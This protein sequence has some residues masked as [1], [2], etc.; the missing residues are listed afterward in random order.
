MF[1]EF[2]EW[3]TTDSWLVVATVVAGVCIVCYCI[4]A[5]M[6]VRGDEGTLAWIVAGGIWSVFLIALFFP[7][8]TEIPLPF[9]FK[10]MSNWLLGLGVCFFVAE[11]FIGAYVAS[12]RKLPG[13]YHPS[14]RLKGGVRRASWVAIIVIGLAVASV[15]VVYIVFRSLPD[16]AGRLNDTFGVTFTT[17]L[18][19][20]AF[21]CCLGMAGLLWLLGAIFMNPYRSGSRWNLILGRESSERHQ[22][23]LKILAAGVAFITG[24]VGL[25]A[26]LYQFQGN[27]NDDMVI[28]FSNRNN[29]ATTL[30]NSD[31]AHVRVTALLQLAT[32]A[33]DYSR[34]PELDSFQ[35][36][37]DAIIDEIVDYLKTPFD[38]TAETDDDDAVSAE[39]SVRDQVSQILHDHLDASQSGPCHGKRN[40]DPAGNVGHRGR[41]DPVSVIMPRGSGASERL[42]D[43][44]GRQ[45][46]G[47]YGGSPVTNEESETKESGPLCWSDHEFD[48]SQAKFW[49]ADFTSSYFLNDVHFTYAYFF[50]GGSFSSAVFEQTADFFDAHFVQVG[51]SGTTEIGW[52]NF[53]EAVFMGETDFRGASF[54]S[55]SSD[56]HVNDDSWDVSFVGADFNGDL[57]FA[58]ATFDRSVTFDQAEFSKNCY[59]FENGATIMGYE[60]WNRLDCSYSPQLNDA[61]FTNVRFATKCADGCKEGVDVEFTNA[62]FYSNVTFSGA[63]TFVLPEFWGTTFRGETWLDFEEP[64]WEYAWCVPWSDD[65]TWPDSREETVDFGDGDTYTETERDVWQDGTVWRSYDRCSRDPMSG[66]PLYTVVTLGA[67]YT[68]PEVGTKATVH[69]TNQEGHE[70]LCTVTNPYSSEGLRELVCQ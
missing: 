20:I 33:D 55:Q 25:F 17:A 45:E 6:A 40:V 23:V 27:H 26:T 37:R 69:L 12:S 70:G 66:R 49:K 8:P 32:L 31:N 28:T 13:R 7:Y 10:V 43:T 56:R 24:C 5:R 47:L 21:L 48:F 60:K 34:H 58:K 14:S 16:L 19:E 67:R 68:A 51:W 38:P 36:N 41:P 44:P 46:D 35:T 3:T 1:L 52:M 50:G 42:S 59:M 54:T 2:L 64:W 22:S 62:I 39:E 61:D 18:W 57:S 4:F 9:W 53:N 30:L 63:S 15:V 29:E 11:L 65:A